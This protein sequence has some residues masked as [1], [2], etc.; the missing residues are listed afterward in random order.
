MEM[1]SEQQPANSTEVTIVTSTT[2]S[3]RAK[4]LVWFGSLILV[5]LCIA[6][7]CIVLLRSSEEEENNNN[8]VTIIVDRQGY[9]TYL[10][11]TYSPLPN[12]PQDQAIEWLAFQ[13]E[14]LSGDEL[15]SRLDQRYALVVLY[16]AHGGT[17]TW[18]SIND[19]SGSG[20]INSGA[21]VHECEWKGV[22]CNNNN[23]N[24]A[25]QIT[26][27]RL[28]A[29]Q[30]I[31]LTGSQLST[32][33]GSY[34]TQL[35]S[36]YMADQR[37]QGSIPSDW[38]TLTNLVI[39]DLSNNEIRSTI[40]DFFGEFDDLQALLLGGNLLSGSIPA[41]LAD[42]NIERLELHF[43]LGIK[44]RIEE[45][46]T[47]MPK[48]TYLDVSSTSFS[49]VLPSTQVQK[50][51]ELHALGSD[52]SGTVPS[53]ISTWSSLVNLNIGHSHITGTIPSEFGLLPNLEGINLSYLS[54]EGTLPTELSRLDSLSSLELR[55]SSF[56]GTLPTEYGQ[57]KDLIVFDLALNG[58]I[59]GGV[60]REYGNMES[61]K[62]LYLH[63]TS[64]SGTIDPAMCLLHMIHFT[65]DCLERRA[66]ELD[67]NC[68]TECYNL[69]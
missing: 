46:L 37:L 11:N 58:E 4:G 6:I 59:N 22:D 40:P 15:L 32:E 14:P 16:Y 62:I 28:S 5:G 2:P 66:V 27:L 34:L 44:G 20:W 12:T 9:Y 23:I 19:S 33:I 55:S 7:I 60:P 54:M 8:G 17:S 35:Q 56:V 41:T 39:L 67:C 13:D 10:L 43:N 24:A 61:L 45:L 31:L 25:R 1:A 30:G 18:N 26:G 36:L 57:L 3:S 29:E 47:S 21:G 52:V 64:L 53:E 48:L 69:P 51:Q 65:A 63:G 50:L 49:G 42:S 68:C 38:K